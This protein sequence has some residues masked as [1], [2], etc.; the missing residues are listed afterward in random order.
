MANEEQER[1]IMDI[2]ARLK[3]DAEGALRSS[4][5]AGIDDQLA[6]IEARLRKGAPPEEY[7]RLKTMKAGLA[8][9]SLVLDRT[10]SYYHQ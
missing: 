6:A 9:A 5:A 7:Q 10:W 4:L 3:D 2:E 1:I 8:S